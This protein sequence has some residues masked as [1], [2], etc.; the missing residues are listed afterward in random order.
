[1]RGGNHGSYGRIVFD[2][3]DSVQYE[4][5]RFDNTLYISFARRAD[6]KF[7]SV[8]PVLDDYIGQPAP[9][10]HGYRLTIPMKDDFLVEDWTYGTKVVIDLKKIDK[11]ETPERPPRVRVEAAAGAERARLTFN[12]PFPVGYDLQQ[13]T[14]AGTAR[15][16]FR[17][18]AR[19]DFSGYSEVQPSQILSLAPIVSAK[20]SGVDL[21]VPKGARIRAAEN[22][23]Q[24]QVTIEAP[25][26]DA[27]KA[28]TKT[29]DAQPDR[30]TPN[31]ET[32]GTDASEAV[33]ESVETAELPE[34]PG[35]EE[36][37]AQANDQEADDSGDA[38]LDVLPELKPELRAPEVAE[39]A[40]AGARRFTPQEVAQGILPSPG[41][42]APSVRQARVEMPWAGRAAAAFARAGAQWLAV[43]GQAPNDFTAQLKQALPDIEK[44]ERQNINGTTLLRMTGGPGLRVRPELDGGLW[45]AILSRQPV[46]PTQPI[47]VRLAEGR[48]ILPVEASGAVLNLRDPATG[49]PLSVVPVAAPGQGMAVEREFPEF[50]LLATHTGIAVLPKADYVTVTRRQGEVVVEGEG[51]ALMINPEPEGE[52]QEVRTPATAGDS[53]LDLEA[54]RRPDM[55]FVEA[56]QQ[57]RQKLADAAPAEKPLVRLE[58]ARF[59][60][61]HGMAVEALGHLELYAKNAPR[62]AD[63]PQVK[64]MRA[65][66][67]LL[68]GD[69][70][71]A[72]TTLN[73]PVL[74]GVAEALPWQAAY[75][76]LTGAY[77]SAAA[78]FHKAEPMLDSYPP[79]VRK[80][81]RLWAAQARIESG[82]LPGAE[83]DLDK[84]RA[85]DPT[86]SEAAQVAFLEGRRQLVAGEPDAAEANW[87]EAAASSHPPSR[88]RARLVLTER[89]L[90]AGEIEIP[91]A[92]AELER[93]RYA[94]RGDEF[95]GV[96]LHRL[97][98]L[99]I[100]EARYG[101]A[102]SALKQAASHLPE[103]PLAQRATARMRRLFTRLFLDGEADRM[104]ALK[105]L[106]LYESFRELTPAGDS[107][108][109]MIA[110]LA[111]RLVGVDL[112]TRAGSLL[113]GQV[114]RR[115]SGLEKA[116]VGTRLAAVRLLDRKPE[117]G[118][119]ALDISKMPDMPPSLE[120]RRRLLRA[121]ALAETGKPDA[122]LSLL[123]G[124]DSEPALELAVDIHSEQGDWGKAVAVL[125]RLL[126]DLDG[127]ARLDPA[128]A[129]RVMRAAVA[130]TLAGQSARLRELSATYGT[131]M[132]ASEHAETFDLLDPSTGGGPVTVAKQLAEVQTAKDFMNSF[133]ARLEDEST[134]PAG[135]GGTP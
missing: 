85:Q 89:Q 38:P 54:W 113:E 12:W 104:P 123:A 42:V 56:K 119:E 15:L 36:S 96:L 34:Q 125:D 13:D 102:L 118:L 27:A 1:M 39:A 108:D 132:A 51:Q 76:A 61:A 62:R 17:R 63:D 55:S 72:A 99:Y 100:E 131:A 43:T 19:F 29:E 67:Q 86:R 47:E 110:R 48:A 127:D 49:R 133:S 95:E 111:D 65:A 122:A 64:L 134:R 30:L 69:W 106:A 116:D 90:A 94:W 115:L 18:P 23:T 105:A 37:G 68:A 2:W 74:D 126:P 98:D 114:R 75:A 130:M 83:V 109:E 7:W 50:T 103:S 16:R 33:P 80:Q 40:L 14:K 70:N 22:G 21:K 45:R 97:A 124:M 135:G 117:D 121:R 6:F 53:L 35:E 107:G 8:S 120:A 32:S 25:A 46:L 77:E 84:V 101:R 82:D 52:V 91:E 26:R 60:F 57:L 78:A 79:S 28:A 4:V 9:G 71:T 129:G 11:P 66:S 81:L 73:D 41:E 31:D 88:T 58:L 112:L 87:R 59:H 128:G 5:E 20:Q 44:V 92:I 3:P 24:I 93:L 10:P